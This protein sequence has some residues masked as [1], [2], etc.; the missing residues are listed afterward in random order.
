LLSRLSA[1]E[2]GSTGNCGGGPRLFP[3]SSFYI[4]KIA[5]RPQRDWESGPQKAGMKAPNPLN[6]L[7][8]YAILL[9]KVGERDYTLW[10]SEAIPLY[11]V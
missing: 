7:E 1:P 5:A 9:L 3:L 4:V 6:A 11:K 2:A 10:T 8:N